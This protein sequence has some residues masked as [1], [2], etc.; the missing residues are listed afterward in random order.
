MFRQRNAVKPREY[1]NIAKKLK[2][3]MLNQ[4]L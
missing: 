1:E 4:V 3:K 2:G